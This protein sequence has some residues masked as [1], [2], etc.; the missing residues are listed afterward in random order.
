MTK[1]NLQKIEIPKGAEGLCAFHRADQLERLSRYAPRLHAALTG[2]L[3]PTK[4][5]ETRGE[6]EKAL[7]ALG[8]TRAESRGFL[9]NGWAGLREATGNDETETVEAMKALAEALGGPKK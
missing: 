5:P 1:R 8:F 7:K 4:K 2:N 6:A 3:T 9:A